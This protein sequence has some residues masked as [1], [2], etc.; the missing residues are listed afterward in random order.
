[1]AEQEEAYITYGL[2]CVYTQYI[3][4]DKN[5]CNGHDEA[6]LKMLTQKCSGVTETAAQHLSRISTKDS[7]ASG[8][9][10]T[11]DLVSVHSART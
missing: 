3:N 10:A 2:F 7:L 4:Q 6:T 1:M 8:A 9:V 11:V 5:H